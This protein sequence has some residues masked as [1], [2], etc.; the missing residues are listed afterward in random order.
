MTTRWFEDY[1]VG[2]SWELGE[3]TPSEEEIVGFARH[4]DPQPFEN[5]VLH[6]TQRTNGVDTDTVRSVDICSVR[7]QALHHSN[8][9]VLPQ[10]G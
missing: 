4:Y 6:I 9:I 2:S 10:H 5:A 1:E 7:Q 3:V 8:I